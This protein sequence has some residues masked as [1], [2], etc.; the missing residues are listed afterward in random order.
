MNPLILQMSAL[1]KT[2]AEKHV[3]TFVDACVLDISVFRYIGYK[4][5][6]A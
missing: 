4:Y 3:Y 6:V 5:R 1:D 2:E